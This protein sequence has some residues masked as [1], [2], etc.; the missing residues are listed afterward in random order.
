MKKTKKKQYEPCRLCSGEGRR[1]VMVYRKGQIFSDTKLELCP[2]CYGTCRE[3]KGA[4]G[5]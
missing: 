5:L 4:L 3:L 2:R 1:V